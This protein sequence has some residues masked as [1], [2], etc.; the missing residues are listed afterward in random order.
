MEAI[1][2]YFKRI[3]DHF[4]RDPPPARYS[5]LKEFEREEE[6][7]W[8]TLLDREGQISWEEIREKD[9]EFDNKNFK[10]E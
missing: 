7:R 5:L 2:S 1:R 6:Q 8:T 9:G 4:R 10:P 3:R